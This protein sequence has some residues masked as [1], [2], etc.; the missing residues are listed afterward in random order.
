MNKPKVFISHISE[1]SRIAQ[2]IKS[3]VSA[4]FLGMIDVF[5]SSDQVSISVGSKWLDEVDEAL[6]DAQI[7]LILCSKHSVLRPWINFEAGAGWVKGI[8]IV[9]ICHTGMRPVDLPIPLNMLQ[10]IQASEP[11]GWQRVY[12][13]L[14][15][16]LGSAIPNADFSALVTDVRKFEQEYGLL[17]EVSAAVRALV[18]L[19]PPLAP[20]FQPN[21]AHRGANG[22]V[23][24]LVL[25]KMRPH[26]DLLQSKG[27]LAYATG[28]NKMVFGT[29]GGGNMVE[30]N[31][32]MKAA[33][34]E[35]APRVELQ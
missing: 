8:P 17:R 34:Y 19:L 30:L 16:K 22:D 14:A 24:D 11:S 27:M 5:V 33:F 26:L 20:M 18:K 7:E 1:E 10:G 12:N 15:S 9:P 28:G 31:I 3:Q 2:L 21:P 4:D 6:K 13:L 35:V 32:E 25:D 23:S 29:S